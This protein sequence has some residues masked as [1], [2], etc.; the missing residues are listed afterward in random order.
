MTHYL[1]LA[2][3]HQ[4][5]APLET[6][7]ATAGADV[8]DDGIAVGRDADVPHAGVLVEDLDDLTD[9]LAQERLAA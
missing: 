4:A 7:H 9:V 5:V 8:E 3:D 6:E 1:R 2:A